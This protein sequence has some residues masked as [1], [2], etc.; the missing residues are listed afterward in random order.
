MALRISSA[1]LDRQKLHL[2]C[3]WHYRENRARLD[4]QALRVVKIQSD[5]AIDD[6][7]SDMDLKMPRR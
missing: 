1:F 2:E 5:L 7:D 6:S 4:C 3:K